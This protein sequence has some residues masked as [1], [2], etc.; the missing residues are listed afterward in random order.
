MLCLF[1]CVC[2]TYVRSESLDAVILPDL[3]TAIY[4]SFCLSLLS[5]S[6]SLSSS[7][8]GVL[9]WLSHGFSNALPQPVNSSKLAN[10]EVK[11]FA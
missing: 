2:G 8:S 9:S 1:V 7:Q 11:V 3:I 6:L 10:S 5:L 4:P